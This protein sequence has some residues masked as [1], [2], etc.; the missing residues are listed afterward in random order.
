LSQI[1]RKTPGQTPVT[2]RPKLETSWLGL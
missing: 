1:P 2:M